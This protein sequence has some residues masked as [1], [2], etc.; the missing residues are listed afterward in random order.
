MKGIALRIAA[1]WLVVA[2]IDYFF[3]RKQVDRQLRMS[4]EE[5]RQEMKDAETSPE[6][7]MAQ[8]RRRRMNRGRM[9]EAVKTAD[10]II[11]NPTH[12]S[13]AVKYKPGK[14]HAPMVVAKG[15]DLL[16]LK[17]REIAKE[18]HIPIVPNPP[19]ARAL[20]KECELGDYVPRELFQ[21]VAEV[22]AYV[23]KTIG[24][25]NKRR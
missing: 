16:A 4:K 1:T 12:Y 25:M 19:L 22:L 20:Y 18:H 10:A 24:G 23:Y 13:V 15:L 2:G 3:Q 7:K 14:D 21:G 11:T 8:A 9:M 17:I 6:L 5:V